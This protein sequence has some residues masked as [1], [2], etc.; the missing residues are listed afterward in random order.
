[1]KKLIQTTM[2][3]A[4]LLFAAS[5]TRAHAQAA[6]THY[7][8]AVGDNPTADA[9]IKT[10]TDFTNALVSGD[11]TKAK[12][13][14]A[15]NYKGY[16][17][18]ATDSVNFDQEITGWQENYKTQTDRKVG[19]VPATFQVLSGDLQ[20]NWV[21]IWGDYTFTEN[22]K[23]ITFPFHSASHVTN[24]KIDRNSIYYD[25]LSILQ[26]LGYT[27]TPPPASK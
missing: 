20:G 14:M 21:A 18:A 22:G 13:L 27:L 9:D 16:G 11:L 6:P 10:V 8:D 4:L 23:T 5:V 17:P 26:A 1:M 25:R 24:G 2:F 7:K 12:S 3:L 19:F 15:S